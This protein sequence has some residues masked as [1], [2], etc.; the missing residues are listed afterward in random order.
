[1]DYLTGNQFLT[2]NDYKNIEFLQNEDNVGGYA[3]IDTE[4][5]EMRLFL[6]LVKHNE[7]NL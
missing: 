6:D 1:M 4:A 5:T 2:I 3:Y 7:D